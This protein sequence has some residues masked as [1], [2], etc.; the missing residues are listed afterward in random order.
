MSTETLLAFAG[1]VVVAYVVPG[2]DWMV[3]LRN[4]ARGRRFGF[5]AAA[6]V[7][8]G[9]CVHMAAAA[10]GVSAAML[11]SPVA[12]TVL[13]FAGAAYLIFLGIQAILQSRRRY[14]DNRPDQQPDPG[15]RP[16]RLFW[17]AFLSNVLNPKAALFFVSILPQFLDPS[18]PAASQVL[19]LGTLD[20][21]VGV[22]WWALFVLLTARLSTLMRRSGPR[23]TLDRVTGTALV[24]LGVTLVATS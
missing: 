3:V 10:L 23:R 9:L 14:G 11:H 24:G 1:I 8:C 12:F 17:Q 13:K 6:G 16:A 5:L 2:P 4:S 20:I 15:T 22:L 7:Q 21:A 18:A 19:L